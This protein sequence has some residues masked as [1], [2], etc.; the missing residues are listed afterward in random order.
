MEDY[1]N[2]ERRKFLIG[3]GSLAAGAAAATG[4]GAFSSVSASRSLEVQMADDASALVGLDDID[5]SANRDYVDV[6]GD[7]VSIDIS[8]DTNNDSTEDGIGL[9]KNATTKIL[10]LFRI[11]NNGTQ[12]VVVYTS[13]GP[14]GVRFAAHGDFANADGS[15]NGF[16]LNQGALSIT[17]NLDSS[18]LKGDMNGGFEGAPVLKPGD[19]IEVELFSYGASDVDYSQNFTINAEDIDSV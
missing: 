19:S 12:D 5:S 6:S 14:S 7:T 10:N 9:N 2:M 18:N 13:G 8:T 15:Y 17:S 3:A 11:T 4:T 1:D 16:A